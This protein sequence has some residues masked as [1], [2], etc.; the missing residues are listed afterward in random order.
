MLSAGVRLT[1]VGS[2]LSHL[3][4]QRIK[5]ARQLFGNRPE[6]EER[7]VKFRATV[8]DQ[9][10]LCGGHGEE[11]SNFCALTVFAPPINQLRPDQHCL[12]GQCQ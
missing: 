2:K 6:G 9:V 4:A 12:S 11:E 1:Q 10:E 8:F 5:S 3:A 7:C